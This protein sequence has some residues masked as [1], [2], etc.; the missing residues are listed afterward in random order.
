MPLFGTPTPDYNGLADKIVKKF[1]ENKFKKFSF[2]SLDN[3]TD[4]KALPLDERIEL[5]GYIVK[6]PKIDDTTNPFFLD[7]LTKL[8]SSKIG[9]KSRRGKSRRSKSRRSKSRRTV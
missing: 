7:M 3:Y 5:S 1:N 6:H 4:I 2:D 9:G 8:K